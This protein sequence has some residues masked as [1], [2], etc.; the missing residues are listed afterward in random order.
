VAS[1]SGNS[2][3]TNSTSH[4]TACNTAK[5]EVIVLTVTPTLST[6]Q[7]WVPNADATIT[8]TAGGDL[9]GSVSF[10]LYPTSDC[11]GTAVYGPVSVPMPA[12]AGL[13][14]TLSTSNTKEIS[15]SGSFSWLVS[16]DSTNPAQEDLAA[17]CKEVTSL[18]INNSYTQPTP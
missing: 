12:S 3:N 1:Y 7:K 16:Y 17:T 4:N 2:P 9:K 6:A 13:T 8:A 15:A 5:E 18:T 10:T 14:E 11:T